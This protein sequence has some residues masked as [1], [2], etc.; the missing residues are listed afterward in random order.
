MMCVW[1]WRRVRTRVVSTWLRLLRKIRR[2]HAYVV[3][4]SLYPGH[5]NLIGAVG[6]DLLSPRSV[7]RFTWFAESLRL[8]MPPLTLEQDIW[9]KSPLAT[10]V[11]YRAQVTPP[12]PRG[13]THP[14]KADIW[15]KCVSF[16]QVAH[17]RPQW[18]KRGTAHILTARTTAR[19]LTFN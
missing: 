6:C 16:P 2:T 4:L 9:L 12:R 8:K 1:D 11:C 19:R 10:L 18:H 14:L 17:P 13:W 15:P 5:V 7:C 3:R